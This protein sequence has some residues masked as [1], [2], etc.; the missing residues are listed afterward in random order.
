[1]GRVCENAKTLYDRSKSTAKEEKESKG[2]S[3]KEIEKAKK[4]KRSVEL[5]KGTRE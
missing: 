3:N 4:W 2:K 1:M 5:S